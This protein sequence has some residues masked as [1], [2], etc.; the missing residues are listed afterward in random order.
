MDYQPG[1]RVEVKSFTD[2]EILALIPE[3][4][5]KDYETILQEGGQEKARIYLQVWYEKFL[6]GES[7]RSIL[8][9]KK[10]DN[11]EEI[12][13]KSAERLTE[14][15]EGPLRTM[16]LESDNDDTE[17]GNAFEVRFL[18][19]LSRAEDLINETEK[20][21]EEDCATIIV[22]TLFQLTRYKDSNQPG[23]LIGT[24]FITDL[25]LRLSDFF[26]AR[27]QRMME[28]YDNIKDNL[29]GKEYSA[30]EKMQKNNSMAT[31][32]H[33]ADKYEAWKRTKP[34]E[35]IAYNCLL[36]MFELEW[37]RIKIGDFGDLI[38][39]KALEEDE[40]IL[41]KGYPN[42]LV[43]REQFYNLIHD[44]DT[45]HDRTKQEW[46]EF[47]QKNGGRNK[48][49]LFDYFDSSGRDRWSYAQPLDHQWSEEQPSKL[50]ID[51][52]ITNK[53]DQIF[54]RERNQHRGQVI[55]R[56][57]LT[58]PTHAK[59]SGYRRLRKVISNLEDYENLGQIVNPDA[60]WYDTPSTVGRSRGI[61]NKQSI[62]ALNHLQKTQ[63]EINTD[64]LN[65]IAEGFDKD[66]NILDMNSPS[67][68]NKIDKITIKREC[69]FYDREKKSKCE[70][71]ACFA[72]EDTHTKRWCRTHV[73]AEMKT[74][75]LGETEDA[76]G[77]KLPENRDTR[78]KWELV[79]TDWTRKI[80]S[81]NGNVF[82]HVWSC[83]WRGRLYPRC[84]LLSPQESDIDRA[85]IR[86]KEWKPLGESGWKW[87]RIHLF[88]LAAGIIDDPTWEDNLKKAPFDW[89]AQWVLD[90][91]E[92]FKEIAE[93]PIK[94]ID[95]W[96]E[97]PKSKGE[98]MQRLAAIL[99]VAR[100]Y[101][102]HK[103]KG[104]KPS[105]WDKVKSGMPV[106]L[107]GSCN[108]YQHLSALLRNEDLA[109]K[110]NVLP[111]QISESANQEGETPL[112]ESDL[113]LS[114][115]NEARRAYENHE[116]QCSVL[117][118][119]DNLNDIFTPKVID[120]VFSRKFAKNITMTLAYGTKD[121]QGKFMGNKNGRPG[122]LTRKHVYCGSDEASYHCHETD[123]DHESP[124]EQKFE[125]HLFEKHKDKFEKG[126]HLIETIHEVDVPDRQSV[127]T[128]KLIPFE[129]D[130]PA[131]FEIHIQNLNR[132]KNPETK[133]GTIQNPYPYGKI[134][135]C[136]PTR[137]VVYFVKKP[138]EELDRATREVKRDDN[139]EEDEDDA[140]LFKFNCS[141][142]LSP[143]NNR[144]SKGKTPERF[145]EIQ[146]A[147]YI[148]PK[149]KSTRV[150][151]WHETSLL[152]GLLG[153]EIS[154]KIPPKLQAIM[155]TKLGADYKKAV[156]IVTAGVNK[157][158]EDVLKRAVDDVEEN[159]VMWTTPI[160][161]RVLNY[162]PDR[163]TDGKY[164]GTHGK[165]WTSYWGDKLSGGNLPDIPY[166][167]GKIISLDPNFDFD[168]LIREA[169]CK[170][171]GRE[172][173][174]TILRSIIL[175]LGVDPSEVKE[176][177][178]NPFTKSE[179][180]GEDFYEGFLKILNGDN[181]SFHH[182]V[183]RRPLIYEINKQ[184]RR[185]D[186]FE[187]ESSRMGAQEIQ[188]YSEFRKSVYIRSTFTPSRVNSN[189]PNPKHLASPE[190][191]E[192]AKQVRKK[193]IREMKRGITPNF[194]QSLD[195]AHMT[196]VINAICAN[197]TINDFWAVHD[198]F[199]VHP[200]DTDE[201][202][203][204]VKH[205][206]KQLHERPL[207]AWIKEINPN[208]DKCKVCAH[209]QRKEKEARWKQL[210]L[211]LDQLE[212]AQEKHLDDPKSTGS[213]PVWGEGK[214]AKKNIED[215]KNKIAKGLGTNTRQIKIHMDRHSS[216]PK[217]T[218]NLDNGNEISDYFIT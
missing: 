175:A 205:T 85:L 15:F 48:H 137:T 17:G 173:D 196:M 181:R 123:C 16:I 129:K 44:P 38:T 203:K 156:E 25:G 97:I 36:L 52:K 66:Q 105:D 148:G 54:A 37:L 84:T 124:S 27:V 170:K 178:E 194:V 152:Y 34:F 69:E 5:K 201:L 43:F 165:W 62:D 65:T 102:E 180:A 50:R 89:R 211:D 31:K 113:Y 4:K 218:F 115:V 134:M 208:Q 126:K 202:V 80:L 67:D 217:P 158:V 163:K 79:I 141:Y 179:S 174:D 153:E 192:R 88:N 138:G 26:S 204:T 75:L 18:R 150:A 193:I 12:A 22:Q 24:D 64:L 14:N 144:K 33:P 29:G 96:Q 41:E 195:G 140:E 117:F 120:Q 130:N 93:D 99:E 185:L 60:R 188:N 10:R 55:P 13:I 187:N 199:G 59:G 77:I 73:P 9:Q 154:N 57:F 190:K 142:H 169:Y 119:H 116:S 107:D 46:E 161:F 177:I 215:E 100:V 159:I 112:P 56:G 176:F 127:G 210:E 61:V 186:P 133:S 160:G 2:D 98:S 162:Y 147:E 39:A 86:F 197:E 155:A 20:T 151:I 132:H 32:P 28:N 168:N 35:K 81:L 189:I 145:N 11:Q 106:Q 184:L 1:E 40:A 213:I 74:K 128:G 72:L 125:T 171:R 87:L 118:R 183:V 30:I 136:R 82:W 110:V 91:I 182:S 111:N 135:T 83:G 71:L 149:W 214:A 7:T 58:P 47:Y 209:P 114:V 78:K 198:C 103:Q 6:R 95:K 45:E 157:S 172:R 3:F 216:I 23:R 146:E 104:G 90:N 206:F 131:R 164:G 121:F 143:T 101:D 167:F 166:Y 21:W 200:S 49:P 42:I 76:K 51:K 94:H 207:S 70:S 139:Y 8:R 68:W 109:K 212:K 191:K 53:E 122:F 63:W 108:V 92:T 19:A